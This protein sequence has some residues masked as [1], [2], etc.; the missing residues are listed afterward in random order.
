MNRQPV[1]G[2]HHDIVKPS[3]ANLA[4]GVVDLPRPRITHP[5]YL[6]AARLRL[7][8]QVHL[9]IIRMKHNLELLH[10]DALALVA[11]SYFV[12]AGYRQAERELSLLRLRSAPHQF[13]IN[14]LSVNNKLNRTAIDKSILSAIWLPLSQTS[15]R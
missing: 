7:I 5:E 10:K 13:M 9:R 3:R 2:Q 15:A 12:P 8:C 1:I 11:Y 6:K 14:R 4:L